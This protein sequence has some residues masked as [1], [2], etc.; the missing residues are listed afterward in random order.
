MKPTAFTEIEQAHLALTQFYRWCQSFDRPLTEGRLQQVLSLMADD[1]V[2]ASAQGLVK[3]KQG[4]LALVPQYKS[5][6]NFHHVQSATVSAPTPET[7]LIEGH[8]LYQSILPNGSHQSYTMQYDARLKTVPDAL[9]IFTSI[10]L[11][12]TGEDE[13]TAFADS[14]PANRAAALVHYWLYCME[15]HQGDASRLREV[16][17]PAFEINLATG[18]HITTPQELSAWAQ[19]FNARIR[20]CSCRLRELT[21]QDNLDGTLSVSFLVD[22]Q[23]ISAEEEPMIAEMRHNWLLQDNPDQRFPAIKR[24]DVETL[25]PMQVVYSF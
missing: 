15:T 5:W 10:Q 12:P 11:T 22:W 23:G 9:P 18:K 3:G 20:H 6:Q 19:S 25:Q 1:V 13:E 24:I 16:L 7:L 4:F 14:Y 17:Y 2:L 21:A 8:V